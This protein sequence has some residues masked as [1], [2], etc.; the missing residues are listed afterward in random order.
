MHAL[1]PTTRLY[2][3]AGHATQLAISP[4][5]PVSQK[6]RVLPGAAT[7]LLGHAT[8]VLLSL[9]PTA[10]EY[11]LAGQNVHAALPFVDLNV[12][13]GQV[14]HWPLEAPVSGPVYPVLHWHR[15]SR[16]VK[17]TPLSMPSV[18]AVVV[19]VSRNSSTTKKPAISAFK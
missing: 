13:G 3:P 6:H 15:F 9:A 7:E 18:I 8:H 10:V 5:Y 12:P 11:V 1:L 14:V 16:L 19:A 4:V 17:S 2:L